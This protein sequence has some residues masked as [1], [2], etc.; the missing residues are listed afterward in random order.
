VKNRAHP[1]YSR[2]TERSILALPRPPKIS[3]FWFRKIADGA[4]PNRHAVC[5]YH[6]FVIDRGFDVFHK[7]QGTAR[8]RAAFTARLSPA[9]G[10]FRPHA[11]I[12]DLQRVENQLARL[13][14]PSWPEDV[15]G[16][17][18]R[19]KAKR[20][21]ALFVAPQLTVSRLSSGLKR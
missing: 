7:R 16:K 19:E 15:F 2:V 18:D 14:P 11:A 4:V 13:A 9:E 10:L 21:K 12:H 17:I 6:L 1:A 20:G 5:R 3:N 8:G